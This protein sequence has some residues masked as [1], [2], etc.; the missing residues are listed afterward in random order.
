MKIAV[1]YNRD[2]KSVINLF[3]MPNQERIGLKTI[4]WIVEALKAGGHQAVSFEGDKAL[5]D[6]LEEFMPRVLKGER[7][8]MVFNLSYGI[9]GQARYT[10]VPSILEMVG[11]PYVGSGPL[12]HSLALDKV[13]SKIIFQKNGVPTADFAVLKDPGFDLPDLS[14]PL[15]VKPKNEAVSF[16]IRVVRNEK[17]LREAAGIIFDRFSQPVL[18]E[19]YIDGREI[20]VG[21]LGNNPPDV[22]PPAEILFGKGPKIYSYEDKNRRSGREI[23]IRCPARLSAAQRERAQEIALSAFQSLGC[24]DCARVDMRLDRRGDFYVLEINSLP[25]L[26]EHGSYTHAAEVAG[27][28]Y[29]A[30]INRL[31]EVASARYFGTPHPPDLPTL[32]KG[33]PEPRQRIFSFIT[34]HRDRMENRL[35]EWTRLSSR[36][37]DPV[38][39]REARR[40]LEKVLEQLGM[41]PVPELSN[42]HSAWTWETGAGA[43]D[44]TLLVLHLDSPLGVDEVPEPFRRDPEWLYGEAIATSRGPLVMLEYALMSLRAQRRLRSRRVGVLFYTDEG[45][46]ALYS[47][48]TVRK[49]ASQA[50]SV[51]VLRP[52]NVDNLF[53][54][55]RRGQRKYLLSVEG[56]PRRLGQIVKRPDTLEWFS[57]RI[58]HISRLS[59]RK[60]RIAVAARHVKTRAFPLLLPH[61]LDATLLV[62]YLDNKRADGV[63]TEIR[64]ILGRT[65]PRWSLELVS[66]RPAMKD[67]VANKRLARTLS[68]ISSQWEIG[69]KSDSSL[70]PSVGGLV[71]GRASVVCGMG[72]VGRNLYTPRES[73]RRITLVQRALILAQFILEQEGRSSRGGD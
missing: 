12:A 49:A 2:S 67:R 46:D 21:L 64:N 3:G 65:G 35:R 24:Y 39:L 17:E 18:A 32:G 19:T 27:L 66:D 55:Q 5:V 40:R 54:H 41:E 34:E 45:R 16:G 14:F 57:D 33:A 70:W 51:I 6:R 68:N 13:V 37:A 56:T 4:R 11:I 63:E 60:D 15:I 20:N 72:P 47:A 9:Q 23:G 58:V 71:T 7:P 26:G 30:L 73:V 38:G 44:G 43:K 29:G 22:L 48:D 36:S 50:R 25:S 31:V 10:H 8:G 42:E 61:R 1:V 69:L 53:V 28:N 52:G 59:S 62:S